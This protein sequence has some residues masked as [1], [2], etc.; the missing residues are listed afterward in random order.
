MVCSLVSN[1]CSGESCLMAVECHG[2]MCH[3]VW[4]NPASLVSS[5]VTGFRTFSFCVWN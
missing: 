3:R 5:D 2:L 1:V 4:M